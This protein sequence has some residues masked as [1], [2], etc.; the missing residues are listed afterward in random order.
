MVSADQNGIA[1]AVVDVNA[2]RTGRARPTEDT[3]TGRT[4]MLV[5]ATIGF[6]L[7]FWA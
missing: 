5:L 3:G 2:G 6:A 1:E 4:R 7:A